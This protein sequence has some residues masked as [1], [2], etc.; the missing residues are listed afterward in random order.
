VVSP[1]ALKLVNSFLDQ[2]LFNFLAI[3]KSTSLASLRPAVVE[4]LKP[5]LAKEAILQADQEMEG[6]LGG[7]DYEELLSYLNGI[8]PSGDWDLELVWKRIRLRCMVYSSLGDM[9]EEDKDHYTELEHLHGPPESTNRYSNPSGVVS[10]AVAVFLTSILEFMGKQALTVAGRAAY[11]RLRSGQRKDERGRSSVAKNVVDHVVVEDVDMERVALDGTLG[12]PRKGWK[13]RIRSP[14]ALNP[15]RVDQSYYRNRIQSQ[16]PRSRVAPE[17][18]VPEINHRLHDTQINEPEEESSTAVPSDKPS[19]AEALS[20]SRNV[21]KSSA[22]GV[23]AGTA[24]N[25]TCSPDPSGDL[26]LHPPTIRDANFFNAAASRGAS[27]IQKTSSSS[28]TLKSPSH[29]DSD[30]KATVPE[31]IVTDTATL[32]PVPVPVRSPLRIKLTSEALSVQDTQFE[33]TPPGSCPESSRDVETIFVAGP[34]TDAVSYLESLLASIPLREVATRVETVN[35]C[36]SWDSR[37]DLLGR[38][39]NIVI[40]PTAGER[41]YNLIISRSVPS[42]VVPRASEGIESSPHIFSQAEAMKI[43]GKKYPWLQQLLPRYRR[44][45]T[46][47]PPADDEEANYTVFDLWPVVAWMWPDAYSWKPVRMA[48]EQALEEG[49]TGFFGWIDDAESPILLAVN[50][51]EYMD[52]MRQE[53]FQIYENLATQERPIGN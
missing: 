17:H 30:I 12:R 33:V 19:K 35:M 39:F 2:L 32:E 46:F 31:V 13:K 38:S 52:K 7:G 4:A 42:K 37:S 9:E 11:H 1:S 6:Y 16:S 15:H 23:A 28:L 18:Q 29:K 43:W 48:N 36:W 8:E 20:H 50:G 49:K 26:F 22:A 45:S 51:Q 25:S 5:K 34:L 3:S 44:R 10:A 27:L 14:D 53:M 47:V 40:N 24:A 21:L 41:Y